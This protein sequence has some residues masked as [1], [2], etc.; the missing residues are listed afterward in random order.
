MGCETDPPARRWER[1]READVQKG[2]TVT[3]W[4]GGKW[5]TSTNGARPSL[6]T[7][8]Q[9]TR[10]PPTQQTGPPCLPHRRRSGR[11]VGPRS[12]R[13][14]QARRPARPSAPSPEGLPGRRERSRH[15]EPRRRTGRVDT[16]ASEAFAVGPGPSP[17][18][19]PAIRPALVPI[20][21]A[22]GRACES[23]T[24]QAAASP[25]ELSPT[26]APVETQRR[27]AD[28]EHVHLGPKGLLG[29][30]SRP[31]R[32]PE[33]SRKPRGRG[34]AN[35]PRGD[36]RSFGRDPR[37]RSPGSGVRGR[38]RRRVLLGSLREGARGSGLTSGTPQRERPPPADAP[39]P[40]DS[41]LCL[42]CEL[43]RARRGVPGGSRGWRCRCAERPP[44][45]PRAPSSVTGPLSCPILSV[46]L[47]QV[48]RWNFPRSLRLSRC[49]FL[50]SVKRDS[51][52]VVPLGQA[53]TQGT[54]LG[55]E[56]KLQAGRRPRIRGSC[57]GAAGVDPLVTGA[58]GS[59][60]PQRPG[61]GRGNAHRVPTAHEQRDPGWLPGQRQVENC[62]PMR[63]G[64]RGGGQKPSWRGGGD[65]SL[66]GQACKGDEE[67]PLQPSPTQRPGRRD[68]TARFAL[69][70]RSTGHLTDGTAPAGL[71]VQGGAP[72]TGAP[73]C[74]GEAP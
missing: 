63:G 49:S 18:S 14:L 74:P 39:P 36:F 67:R 24:L 20:R 22:P 10:R 66:M 1:P 65:G 37:G 58:G 35:G 16:G 2:R 13:S 70:P 71:G 56:A 61:R 5:E 48:R 32:R 62:F 54:V 28:R 42:G 26:A 52:P 60:S 43:C 23:V 50:E 12:S 15:R 46:L 27:R 21:R 29:S 64:W 38:A 31:E 17:L 33:G 34:A 6:T 19:P 59:P 57:Q 72:S 41:P 11:L 53:S 9:G 45:Q 47:S 25:E 68:A 30:G 55:T 8:L 51:R 7:N 40:E 69:S 73:F 4:T 3:A 44:C